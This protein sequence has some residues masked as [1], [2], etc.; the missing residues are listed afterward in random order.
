MESRE[1]YLSILQ[2]LNGNE[3]D[4]YKLKKIINCHFDMINFM[5][6]FTLYDVFSYERKMP[7]MMKESMKMVL[8]QNAELKAEVNTLRKKVG[9]I[10]KYKVK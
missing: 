9:K 6:E 10:E 8:D 2:R 7:N 5:K 4:I 1:M 3:D